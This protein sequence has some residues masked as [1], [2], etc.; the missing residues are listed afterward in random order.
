MIRR[1]F[2]I[3]FEGVNN[4]GKSTIGREVHRLLSIALGRDKLMEDF[5]ECPHATVFAESLHQAILTSKERIY[6][7]QRFGAYLTGIKHAWDTIL[8]PPLEGGQIVVCSR[9]VTSTIAYAAMKSEKEHI[10]TSYARQAKNFMGAGFLPDLQI[11]LS[12][13]YKT[14]Y[15]RLEEGDRKY[16]AVFFNQL[17]H[18][19]DATEE[20]IARIT[21]RTFDYCEYSGAL[22]F[23]PIVKNITQL[24][25]DKIEAKEE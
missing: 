20:A 7:S 6:P 17:R 8:Y 10:H 3:V 19:Y 22:D 14:Y 1:G 16:P 5:I 13:D 9:W 11:R 21:G 23:D 12:V 24:I 25:L 18:S 2:F 4:A 15:S